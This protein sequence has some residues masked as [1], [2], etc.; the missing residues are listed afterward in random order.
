MKQPFAPKSLVALAVG[1]LAL[2]CGNTPSPSGNGGSPG[3][4][5]AQAGG[6]GSGGASASGGVRATGGTNAGGTSGSGGSSATGGATSSGGRTSASGG[7]GSGGSDAGGTTGATG[8]GSGTGGGAG[9]SG[10]AG[11]TAT[12]GNDGGLGGNTATGGATS[13]GGGASGGTGSGGSK[14]TGGSGGNI[15]A[16]GSGGT[17][18]AG[19]GTGGSPRTDKWQIMP[20]GDSITETTCYPQLLSQ[21]LIAKGHSNFTF[22]G[23]RPANQGCGGAPVVQ[24]EGRGGYLVTYLTSDSHKSENRGTMTEML[25]WAAKKPDVV[26]MEYGTNDCWNSGIP[27]A[28]ITNAYSFVL[29]KFRAQNPKVIFFVAQITPLNPSGCTTCESRVESLNAAIPSWAADKTT[30]DSPVY[31]VNIFS[32]LDPKTYLP[33]S[34]WTQDG[35]H[36]LQP[37]AQLM[38]DKWYTDVTAQGLP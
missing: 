34:T 11:S 19:D 37:A 18:G 30:T 26:L 8:G 10:S 38:A 21:E 2:A 20:L 33:N 4:G 36:P 24:T 32:T 1:I 29:E 14:A 12:G 13:N 5:G 35:C 6:A 28:D 17:T 16:G 22:I 31:V 23:D 25:A 7:S 9:G 15:G 3:S 27:I